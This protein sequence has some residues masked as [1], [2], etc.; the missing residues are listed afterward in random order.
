MC[1]SEAFLHQR[2]QLLWQET[3]SRGFLRLSFA[4]AG[5]LACEWWSHFSF[6]VD[7][8]NEISWKFIFSWACH[9]FSCPIYSLSLTE[10]IYLQKQ[11]PW[12]SLWFKEL[13]ISQEEF[14]SI[15]LVEGQL[16][17]SPRHMVSLLMSLR[18][19]KFCMEYFKL[20]HSSSRLQVSYV[21]RNKN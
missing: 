14:S 15:N 21:R 5:L 17:P 8:Y 16:F 1:P 20:S 3:C 2:M 9:S 10:P 11:W 13:W 18:E 12:T 19:K 6:L 4:S 7:F